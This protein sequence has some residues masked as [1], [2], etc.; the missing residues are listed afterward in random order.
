MTRLRAASSASCT[1][2]CAVSASSGAFSA[3]YRS[4]ST[5]TPATSA[6]R[7]RASSS[8]VVI[9]STTVSALPELSSAARRDPGP[10]SYS[11]AD[12]APTRAVARSTCIC[13]GWIRRR[14]ASIRACV[15]SSCAC[16]RSYC[17]T[18]GSSAFHA[19]LIWLSTCP[20]VGSAAAGTP[21]ARASTTA[22]STAAARDQRPSDTGTTLVTGCRPARQAREEPSFRGNDPTDRNHA[23]AEQVSAPTRRRR[24]LYRC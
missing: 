22:P 13:N 20:G 19:S 14:S 11:R 15:A 6:V 8:S 24:S 12:I 9:W 4:R 5:A 7:R 3:R 17:S 10:V 1:A 21:G 2:S 16:T 23:E 18:I